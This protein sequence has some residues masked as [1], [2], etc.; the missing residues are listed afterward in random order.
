MQFIKE[1][2][3]FKDNGG[4][5]GWNGSTLGEST[6]FTYDIM[7]SGLRESLD[8]LVSFLTEPLI[9]LEMVHKE[10]SVLDSGKF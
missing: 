1:D 2:I 7:C 8:I 5:S 4:T 3:L 9:P 6:V 10:L